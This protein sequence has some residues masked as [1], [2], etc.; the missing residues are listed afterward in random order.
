MWPACRRSH[1]RAAELNMPED[2]RIDELFDDANGDL[3]VGELDAAI[4]KYRRCVEANPAF[5]DGWHALGMALMKTGRYGDAIGRGYA[6]CSFNQT[7]SW[8][9][10]AFPFFTCAISKS[11][12]QKPL[13]QKRGSSLGEA[14]CAKKK[15]RPGEPEG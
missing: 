6:Q 9:G 2:A 4:E 3:A 12:K 10:Q 13:A 11:R 1:L 5:F 7:T 14:S 15:K 8:P